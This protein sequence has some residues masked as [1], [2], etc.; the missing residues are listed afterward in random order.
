M[1]EPLRS[2]AGPPAQ[3]SVFDAVV[4]MLGL[5]VGIGIFRTPS[6]VASGVGSEAI[7]ILVWLVGGLV[8]LIGGAVL[9]RAGRRPPPRRG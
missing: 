2:E 7:F 6:L 5:V 9:C 3:L 4:M 8:T 1:T